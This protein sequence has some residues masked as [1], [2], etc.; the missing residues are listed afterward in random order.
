M[1]FIVAEQKAVA[2]QCL[3]KTHGWE[4]Q[5]GRLQQSE[6]SAAVGLRCFLMAF[7]AFGWVGA[8]GLLRIYS[9][10]ST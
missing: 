1:N 6:E 2:P 8:R 5:V 10:G 7:L 9:K 3:C 4:Q